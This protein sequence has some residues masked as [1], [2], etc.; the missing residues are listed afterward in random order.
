MSQLTALKHCYLYT[1]VATYQGF[2]GPVKTDNSDPLHSATPTRPGRFTINFIGPHVTAKTGLGAYIWSA[3]PWG[4]PLRL[5][6]EQI[7]EVKLAGRDWQRLTSVPA[8]H[9]LEGK[10]AAVVEQIKARNAI[11]WGTPFAVLK[12]VNNMRPMSLYKPIPDEWVFSDFGHVTIKYY[13][14]ANHNG[15]QDRR[16]AAENTYSDF[17]HTTPDNELIERL[18]TKADASLYLPLGPSHGCIHALPDEVDDMISARYL[19]IGGTFVVHSYT[20]RVIGS[21][22]E[23]TTIPRLQKTEVHFYPGQHQLVV[24]M[25]TTLR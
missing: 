20:D 4:T 11:L 13:L 6:K 14:D 17:I 9:H 7:V 25:V 15:R 23:V 3:V 19:T 12:K 22:Q 8:W 21:F 10:Q 2:G 18:N 1:R 16:N 5:T 24:F